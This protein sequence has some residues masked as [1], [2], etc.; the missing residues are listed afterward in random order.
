ME[1]ARRMEVLP[2]TGGEVRA[3]V[4]IEVHRYE[5][6]TTCWQGYIQPETQEWIVFVNDDGSVWACMDRDVITGSCR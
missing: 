6:Q 5:P 2:D 3:M 1:R 4:N